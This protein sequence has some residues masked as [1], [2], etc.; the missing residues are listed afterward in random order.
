MSCWLVV[1]K[2]KFLLN[3]IS[4]GLLVIVCR[5]ATGTTNNY[6]SSS[7]LTALLRTDGQVSFSGSRFVAND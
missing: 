5:G 2:N 7:G 4:G 1:D 3:N 6:D